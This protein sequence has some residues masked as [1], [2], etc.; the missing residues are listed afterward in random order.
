MR[1]KVQHIIQ[2]DKS[3]V[4]KTPQKRWKNPHHAIFTI[5]IMEIFGG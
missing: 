5:K 4:V 3:S 1:A 2:T